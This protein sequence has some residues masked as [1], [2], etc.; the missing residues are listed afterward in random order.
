MDEFKIFRNMLISNL[1]D[2]PIPV[3][4]KLNFLLFVSYS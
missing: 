1:S 3:Y 4:R 2:H